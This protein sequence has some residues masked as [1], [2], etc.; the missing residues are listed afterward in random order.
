MVAE[1]IVNSNLQPMHARILYE[2]LIEPV[3]ASERGP[4]FYL[5]YGAFD[6]LNCL[7]LAIVIVPRL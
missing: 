4:A 7:R 1:K 3:S 5:P 6:N 2:V